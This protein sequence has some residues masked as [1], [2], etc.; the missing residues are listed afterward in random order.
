M[1]QEVDVNGLEVAASPAPPPPSVAVDAAYDVY[2]VPVDDAKNDTFPM[3][4]R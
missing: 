1:R 2:F 3:L 4:P